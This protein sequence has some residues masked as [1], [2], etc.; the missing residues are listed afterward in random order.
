[1]REL[2]VVQVVQVVPEVVVGRHP[3]MPT[4]TTTFR[5][6]FLTEAR[7]RDHNQGAKL[8]SRTHPH[9]VAVSQGSLS[10]SPHSGGHIKGQHFSLLAFFFL[11]RSP[12]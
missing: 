12:L 4:I 2:Q 8:I 10:H 6:E 9:P 5:E 7:S 11:T 3:D 1:M